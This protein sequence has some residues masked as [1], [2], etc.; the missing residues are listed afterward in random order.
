M[1]GEAAIDAAR[2]VWEESNRSSAGNGSVMRCGA[3]A[4]RWMHDDAALARNSTISAAVTHWDPR[5]VWSTLFADFAIAAC[6][7]GETPAADTLQRRA[8]AAL[9]AARAD[10]APF[11]LPER[12]SPDVEAA[13][14]T[15]LAEG[16]SVDDLALDSHGI[17][18]ALKALGAVLWASRHP[19]TVE[20]G[21]IAIVNAGGDTD[22]NAAPA[23]AALGARFGLHG[24]PE[25]WRTRTAEI[26]AE[27][28]SP[29]IEGWI[30]RHPLESYADCL[31]ARA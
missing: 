5:C 26:R 6:L 10:L 2:L 12:P 1:S 3:V 11:D 20:E 9:R 8:T 31:L 30:A 17:G 24:I 19:A 14:E 4:L 22:S 7:R 28:A 23:G 18:Y 15:A 21:L 29:P 13:V 27:E 25:R 16:T